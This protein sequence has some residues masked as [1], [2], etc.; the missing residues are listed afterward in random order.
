MSVSLTTEPTLLL[1]CMEHRL[2]LPL[3]TE[4]ME[5][6]RDLTFH[7]LEKPS[8]DQLWDVAHVF[9]LQIQTSWIPLKRFRACYEFQAPPKVKLHYRAAFVFNGTGAG[10][11]GTC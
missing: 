9:L 8:D 7:F 3:S 1:L 2:A 11:E 5:G 4:Q 10:L 6:A